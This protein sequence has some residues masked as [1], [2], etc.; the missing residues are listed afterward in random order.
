MARGKADFRARREMLGLT[1]Q[2]VADAL[3]ANVKTIKNWENPRQTRYRIS[4][5]AWEFLDC[6]ADIQARQVAYARCV[7]EKHAEVF[8]ESP[9]VVPI[10]YYRDQ[11]AYDE[12][13]RD[14]GPYGQANATSRAIAR[15]LERMGVQVEFR[16]ADSADA[17]PDSDN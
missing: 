14:A 9:I 6:A 4:D 11:A 3:N 7:I 1:Q 12:C 16:Y 15:E 5:A 2:D 13:G 8:A 17:Q 10:T